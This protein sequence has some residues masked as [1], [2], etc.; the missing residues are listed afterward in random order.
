MGTPLQPGPAQARGARPRRRA[1]LGAGI[2]LAL[3]AAAVGWLI[4]AR[5]PRPAP[6]V[7]L[8]DVVRLDGR[9]VLRHATNRPFSGWLVERYAAGTL[10]SRSQVRA[11]R[12]D[13]LSE[14]WYTNGTLQIREHFAAG[15]AEGAVT[16]W[17]PDGTKLSEGLARDGRLDGVFRR[18]HANGVLAE[19]VTLRAGQPHGTSRAWFPSGHPKAEV[20]LE[21]GRVLREQHWPDEGASGLAA[22]VPPEAAPAGGRSP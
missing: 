17:H 6:T 22:T 21:Q 13:G 2:A 4:F 19:E 8:A 16:K 20:V 3:L 14:G 11:G 7:E 15:I 12:L 10:K 1:W 18:W 9:L 5:T